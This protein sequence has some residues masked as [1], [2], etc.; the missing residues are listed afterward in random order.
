MSKAKKVALHSY[1]AMLRYQILGES[2]ERPEENS[3]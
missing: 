3:P 1:G 2:V